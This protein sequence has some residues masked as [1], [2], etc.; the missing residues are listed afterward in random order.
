MQY[1]E[2]IPFVVPIN[3]N[4]MINTGMEVSLL[5]PWIHFSKPTYQ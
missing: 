1:E 5:L 4:K 3:L 2:D